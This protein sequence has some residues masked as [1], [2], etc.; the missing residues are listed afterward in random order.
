[1]SFIHR[2]AGRARIALA[3]VV[4]LVVTGASLS[5]YLI[6]RARSQTTVTLGDTTSQDRLNISVFVQ[7]VDPSSQIVS[8]QVDIE[9]QGTVADANGYPKQ[10]LTITTTGTKGDTMSFKAGRNPSTTDLQVPLNNGVVTDYPF[11]GYRA[12]FGF[13]AQTKDEATIPV[14]VTFASA[15]SFFAFGDFA[16][17][18]TDDPHVV[19]FT[20]Q[21]SRSFGTL[22]FAL[23]IMV[24]M[25]S[26]SLAAVI[27]AWFA[28]SGKRGLLWPSMSFMGALLFALVPLRNAVPG[29]PPIGSVVDFSAF[30][31]AEALISLS[32]ITT[33]VVGYRTERANERAAAQPVAPVTSA[34]L[35]AGH[36]P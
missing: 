28:V 5:V 22:V 12:E 30:F 3:V 2:L 10:D 35:V 33:V 11:D 7:K 13:A 31:I 14:N 23:F 4:V 36:R 17:E 25:W 9:P 32:L 1:M 24:F 8:A 21:A 20:A 6:E 29:Q 18:K 19:L 26:L 27:A 16:A 15:D 34:E